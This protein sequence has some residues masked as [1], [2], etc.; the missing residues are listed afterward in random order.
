MPVSGTYESIGVVGEE[1]TG[2]G[3]RWW[4]TQLFARPVRDIDPAREAD[5]LLGLINDAR[6]GAGVS[7]LLTDGDLNDV[8]ADAARKA[9]G[10]S[11][12]GVSRSALDE[13]RRRGLLTGRLRAWA[14]TTPEI[15]RI[16]LPG[17]LRKS[18]VRRLGIGIDQA[19]D[20][21]GTIGVVLLLAE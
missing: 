15:A 2:G 14:A 4:V 19:R 9:T 17:M 10:G 3:K 7:A 16:K 20:A 11:L 5:R 1:R 6:T 8:A 18:S 13:A 12:D 21:S